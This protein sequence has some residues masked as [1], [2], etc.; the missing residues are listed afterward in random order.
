MTIAQKIKKV[1]SNWEWSNLVH[2]NIKQA[3]TFIDYIRDESVVLKNAKVVRMNTPEQRI[4]Y[5]DLDSWEFLH[6]WIRWQALDANKRQTA[7]TSEKILKTQELVWEVIIRDDELED[8]IEGPAFREHLMRMLAKKT[9]NELEVTSLYA[10]TVPESEGW[11][12]KINKFDWFIS[13]IEKAWNVY[14]VS[15]DP[16][17]DNREIRYGKL[18]KGWKTL[19]TKFRGEPKAIYMPNDLAVNYSVYYNQNTGVKNI[20]TDSFVGIPFTSANKMSI[21]RPV[22]VESWYSSSLTASVSIWAT[23]ITVADTTWLTAGDTVTF[24]L[25][26]NKEFSTTVAS[27]TNATTFVISDPSPYSLNSG[28]ITDNTV[29]ETTLDGTDVLITPN[30]NLYY[31]IQRD[32]TIEAEREA[33]LRATKFVFTLRVDF[34]VE[35]EE[36]AVLIKNLQS[37][38]TSNVNI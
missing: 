23:T 7:N 17:A 13:R 35:N 5:T 29:T 38:W 33:S 16:A 12:N 11:V 9:S 36:R 2:L 25:W 19:P 34:Q 10:K 30:D 37:S 26:E 15:A 31:G 3:D 18:A 24:A 1:F 4:G 20:P 32:I 21:E 28:N 14:D 6:P 22:P 27:V 8:N